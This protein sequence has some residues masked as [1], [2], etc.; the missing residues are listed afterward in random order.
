MLAPAPSLPGPSARDILSPPPQSAHVLTLTK[1]P[2]LPQ[3]KFGHRVRWIPQAPNPLCLGCCRGELEAITAGGL[4][5]LRKTLRTVPAVG[6]TCCALLQ[7]RG[8][9]G[10]VRGVIWFA[11]QYG[12][13]CYHHESIVLRLCAGLNVA[14]T[15]ARGT[16]SC[17]ALCEWRRYCQR[18][19]YSGLSSESV[20][21]G[22]CGGRGLHGGQGGGRGLHGGQG[23]SRGLHGGQGRGR[24]LHGGQGGGR[25][26]HAA[27]GF[28]WSCY[29]WPV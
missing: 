17:S 6:A 28:V 16:W 8:G 26:L 2:S 11:G 1:H 23:G 22:G 18:Y 4:R 5:A 10:G 25:E 14:L 15:R 21:G 29:I 7:A 9:G 27:C 20:E 13:G 3:H 12:L 19:F 24:G